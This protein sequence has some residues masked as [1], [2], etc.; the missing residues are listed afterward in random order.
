MIQHQRELFITESAFN[1]AAI[2]H[3]HLFHFPSQLINKTSP[4]VL[5]NGHSRKIQLFLKILA[6][7]K[8]QEPLQNCI[9]IRTTDNE[10]FVEFDKNT[11]GNI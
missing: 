10:A 4:V 1:T 5:V 9:S 3:Y 8:G 11:F 6:L 7:I 2:I